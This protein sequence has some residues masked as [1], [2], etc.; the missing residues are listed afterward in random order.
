MPGFEAV[1]WQGVVVPAGTPRAIVNRLQLEIATA[2][3]SAEVSQRLVNEGTTPGGIMPD[4]F[5]AYIRSEIA[6][7]AKVVKIAGARAD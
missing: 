1:S 5:A 2:L 3:Q 7:W 4:A 6:K